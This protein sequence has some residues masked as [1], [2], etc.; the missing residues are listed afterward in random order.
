MTISSDS[1]AEKGVAAPVVRTREQID[2]NPSK[3]AA[4]DND[5]DNSDITKIDRLHESVN[6]RCEGCM[7]GELRGRGNDKASITDRDR[8]SHGS[9][10]DTTDRSSQGTD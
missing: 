5:S 6:E 2:D 9:P 1:A 7:R 10:V 3:N 4:S 8:G